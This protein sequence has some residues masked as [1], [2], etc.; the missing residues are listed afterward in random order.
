MAIQI[1]KGGGAGGG[2][3]GAGGEV[4]ASLSGAGRNVL[5]DNF[6]DTTSAIPNKT[7]GDTAWTAGKSVTIDLGR[8]LGPADNGHW[9]GVQLKFTV[10]HSDTLSTFRNVEWWVRARDFRLLVVNA[11]TGGDNI[12]DQFVSALQQSGQT[13]RSTESAHSRMMALSRGRNAAGNDTLRLGFAGH[14]ANIRP[15]QNIR[16]RAALYPDASQITVRVSNASANALAPLS[17]VQEFDEDD[18]DYIVNVDG[19]AQKVEKGHTDGHTKVVEHEVLAATRFR[20]FVHS[21]NNVLAPLNDE[22][23]YVLAPNNVGGGFEKYTTAG[24]IGFFPNYNPFAEGEPW[25]EA[26]AAAT[27]AGDLTYRGHVHD[28]ANMER[29]AGAAGEAFVLLQEQQVVFVDEYMAPGDGETFFVGKPLFSRYFNNPTLVLWGSAQTERISAPSALN[30][31]RHNNTNILL[32]W[33]LDDSELRFGATSDML[34]ILAAADV[35]TD[36]DIYPGTANRSLI[37]LNFWPG[38]WEFDGQIVADDLT[39]DYSQTRLL[40]VV[41]GAAND[42]LVGPSTNTAFNDLAGDDPTGTP[43]Q[44]VVMRLTGPFVQ[45]EEDDILYAAIVSHDTTDE[46]IATAQWLRATYLGA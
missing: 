1:G 31:Y 40:K 29:N 7:T 15:I 9:L 14:P 18:E 5:F 2:G 17:G 22:F 32:K 33:K 37:A 43:E 38:L 4:S 3:G 41:T 11:L 20:G 25:H 44:A 46:T 35:P 30:R 12:P 34:E 26:P 39:N 13:N 16:C 45:V 10:I 23:V 21:V 24:P 8:A 42:K 36:M 28:L 19:T 6:D 27:Y